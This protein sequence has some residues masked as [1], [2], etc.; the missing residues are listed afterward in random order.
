MRSL[1][2]VIAFVAG[3]GTAEAQSLEEA[4]LTLHRSGAQSKVRQDAPGVVVAD[5]INLEVRVVDPAACTVRVTNRSRPTMRTISGE[6]DDK[7]AAPSPNLDALYMEY[8]LGWVI[9]DGVKKVSEVLGTR[10][11]VVVDQIPDARWRLP[12]SPGDEVKCQVWP[13][14]RRTCSDSVEFSRISIVRGLPDQEERTNRVDRAL[15]RIYADLCKGA[16]RR[17]PF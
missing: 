10:N 8:H 1:L 5:D 15:V 11:G 17:V 2:I 7:P 16:A 4:V 9:P 14:G 3:T 12:G 6:W 13:G